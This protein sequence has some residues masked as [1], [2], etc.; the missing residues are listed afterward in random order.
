L[1]EKLE[2]PN[3]Q[4]HREKPIATIEARAAM[5]NTHR[6]SKEDIKEVKED[7]TAL[8]SE[9]KAGFERIEHLLLAEQKRKIEDLEQRMKRVEDALA[10]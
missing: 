7:V 5:I 2:L 3:K 9:M 10:V 6:A 8:R 4:N 1:S